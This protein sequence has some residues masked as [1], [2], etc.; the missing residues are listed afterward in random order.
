LQQQLDINRQ[1]KGGIA[2]RQSSTIAFAFAVVATLLVAAGCAHSPR[3]IDE[4]PSMLTIRADYL[5]SN[6]DGPYNEHIHSG[7]VVKGMNYIEVLASWGVPDARYRTEPGEIEVEYWHYL[8]LDE[9]SHDWTQHTFVFEK[10][11]LVEWDVM[12]HVSHTGSL[13]HWTV[14]ERPIHPRLESPTRNSSIVS[15]KK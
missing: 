9:I 15:V 6:P 3:V 12:R 8:S 1:R 4:S 5:Q 2:M 7:E 14:D 10:K 13:T 11:K